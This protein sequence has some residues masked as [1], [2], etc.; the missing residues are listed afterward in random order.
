[1][2]SAK[3]IM[4]SLPMQFLIGGLTVA[5]IA[6]FSN[7]ISNTAISGVIA[8][9]PIGL[10][11]TIFVDDKKVGGYLNH[12]LVMTFALFIATL[13]LWVLHNKF[14][15]DKYTGVKISMGIWALIGVLVIMFF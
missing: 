7:H 8:S 13:S 9:V 6:Y 5:G 14:K 2:V 11:S 10:P 15:M 1:M 4:N 12:L 3:A